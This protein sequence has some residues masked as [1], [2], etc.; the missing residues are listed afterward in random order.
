[1]GY[2]IRELIIRD[3]SDHLEMIRISNGYNTDIGLAVCRVKT[4]DEG[5]HQGLVIIPRQEESEKK[6]AKMNHTMPLALDAFRLV[7]AGEDHATV[8]EELYADLVRRMTDPADRFSSR[9]DSVTHTG[10]G[11][12]GLPGNE[13]KYASAVATFEIK[14]KTALGNP[15]AQ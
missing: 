4:H 12:P 1:M 10:G 8:G 13:D 7:A 15:E 6:Y 11:P 2:S 5:A 14:Y 9:V 3:L